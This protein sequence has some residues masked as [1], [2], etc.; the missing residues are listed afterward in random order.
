MAVD[1]NTQANW[2]IVSSFWPALNRIVSVYL[3]IQ[4]ASYSTL[5]SLERVDKLRNKGSVKG[6]NSRH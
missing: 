6:L 5:Q 3:L 1:T 2:H 4:R